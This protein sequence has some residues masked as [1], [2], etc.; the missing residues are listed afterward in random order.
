MHLS[1][2]QYTP[3]SSIPVDDDIFSVKNV[4]NLHDDNRLDSGVSVND[5]DETY[6]NELLHNLTGIIRLNLDQSRNVHANQ[7]A[8]T[9]PYNL[10][11][12]TI[13]FF[14]FI[15]FLFGG[16][17]YLASRAWYALCILIPFPFVAVGVGFGGICVP[18][19]DLNFV[20]SDQGLRTVLH[21]LNVVLYCQVDLLICRWW[22]K[23]SYPKA[24]Q[25]FEAED[26]AMGEENEDD[27]PRALPEINFSSISRQNKIFGDV[28]ILTILW[29]NFHPTKAHNP[30]CFGFPALGRSLF[31]FNGAMLHEIFWNLFICENFIHGGTSAFYAIAAVP[32]MS[33]IVHGIT[34]N[35]VCGLRCFPQF[36]WVALAFHA[37]G[38]SFLVPSLIHAMW[39]LTDGKLLCL[40]N[41]HKHA[42]DKEER[43]SET[44]NPNVLFETGAIAGYWTQ[45][46]NSSRNSSVNSSPMQH[47][48]D[49]MTRNLPESVVQSENTLRFRRKPSFMGADVPWWLSLGLI[50][51][52]FGTLNFIEH[53]FVTF[54][55]LKQLQGLPTYGGS[56]K[57]DVPR[58]E[59]GFLMQTSEWIYSIATGSSPT[60][61]PLNETKVTSL[62]SATSESLP[63]NVN[64]HNNYNQNLV[65]PSSNTKSNYIN[66]L[67]RSSRFT[68]S[69][70]ND[71]QN[72]CDTN[73]QYQNNVYPFGPVTRPTQ[74]IL[75]YLAMGQFILGVLSFKYLARGMDVIGTTGDSTT[76]GQIQFAKAVLEEFEK[77]WS[78]SGWT[79]RDRSPRSGRSGG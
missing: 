20:S 31:E 51:V 74:V 61:G 16:A 73:P 23:K 63:I 45:S 32:M 56:D 26:G 58:G 75:F 72:V 7:P 64:Y 41:L 49:A 46:R 70:P 78:G 25:H 65:D 33:C 42:W 35:V 48:P 68:S 50:L 29:K 28:N 43:K 69:D 59:P 5:S 30:I 71:P 44:Q 57:R 22:M 2:Q 6:N 52:W 13:V 55:D 53:G 40:V 34:S 76:E 4:I 47:S 3:F 24:F 21:L 62:L 11:I 9:Q 18:D 37:S 60:V 66:T 79:P 36:L 77:D 67:V 12:T 15:R 1:G 17:P 54:S 38:G 8:F 10:C 14:I 19:V 39:Y 27:S